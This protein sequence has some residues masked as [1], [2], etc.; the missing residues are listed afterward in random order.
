MSSSKIPAFAA[1]AAAVMLLAGC[2]TLTMSLGKKI[3]YKS[4]GTTPTLEIP[5]DLAAPTYDDR[6]QVATASGVAA[7]R[8]QARPSE[9]LPVPPR[10]T[11]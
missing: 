4:A 2:E 3:D 6:Y 9:V 7:Q 5:P 11:S 1:I 8:T 10:F